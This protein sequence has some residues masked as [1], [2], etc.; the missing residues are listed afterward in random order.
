M[1]NDM[2]FPFPAFARRL[3]LVIALAVSTSAHALGAAEPG[4]ELQLDPAPC[5]AASQ[6]NDA[7]KVLTECGA[8][9]DSGK[10]A[11]ADRINALI[12]RASIFIRQGQLDRAIRDYDAVLELDPNLADIFNARGELQRR[13]GNRVKALADFSAALKLKPDHAS[14]RANT[15]S[16]GL[17]LERMGAQIAVAGKPSF[18]CA[19]AR[20]PVET[21][22]CADPT[23]ADLDREIFSVSA[24]VVREATHAGARDGE[25]RR[26]EQDDY[27]ARRNAQFGRPGFDLRKAMLDRLQQ[28]QGVG[29]N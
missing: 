20:R 18:N 11:R 19:Q 22:I 9:I 29:G 4:R 12:A 1:R 13:Q 24:R 8:L 15:R 27:L 16:L 6:A 10:T 28:L 5:I 2:N 23:L 26:R 14:A 21:A 3:L 25:A 7:D 17:E